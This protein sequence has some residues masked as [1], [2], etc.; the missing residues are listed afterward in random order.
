MLNNYRKEVVG[1]GY[2]RH[3]P[4]VLIKQEKKAS[5]RHEMRFGL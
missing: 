1:N 5:K 2:L 4:T 3:P